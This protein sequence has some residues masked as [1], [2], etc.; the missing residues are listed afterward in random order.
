[1]AYE[2][3]RALERLDWEIKK[4]N[5][6]IEDNKKKLIKEILSLD[7][8]KMFIP[9]PPKKKVSLWSKITIALGYGKKR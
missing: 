1:M 7:K 4:D 5:Q 3:Q 9:P 2:V 6:Q 8:T